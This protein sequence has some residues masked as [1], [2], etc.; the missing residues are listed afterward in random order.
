MRRLRVLLGQ[1]TIDREPPIDL[2]V[3]L[4]ADTVVKQSARLKDR[5]VYLLDTRFR[6]SPPELMRLTVEQVAQKLGC[7][8]LTVERMIR[9]GKLAPIEENGEF[10]FD[11]Q[12]VEA[13]RETPI[14]AV[15]S[16]LIPR[17]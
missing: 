6:P 10:Y 12:Q 2:T 11:R 16:R 9:Q 17:N 5:L 1:M 7:R 8:S 15:I 3:E 13:I 4:P 14:S